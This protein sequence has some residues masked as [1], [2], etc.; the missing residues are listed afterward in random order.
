MDLRLEGKRSL[1]TGATAG[2]GEATARMLAAEGALVIANG[3]DS[4]KLDR[5]IREIEA[6]GGKAIPAL[7]DVE[8]D[9][10][11]A[12][13]EAVVRSAC[14]SIDV[15][16][17][18]VGGL[19]YQQHKAWHDVTLDDWMAGYRRN[20]GAA[21]GLINAFVPDMRK[22][23]WG[24]IIN[25]S[26]IAALEPN[27]VPPEYQAAKAALNNLTKSLSKELSASGVTANTITSGVVLT[28]TLEA[29][30]AKIA[31]DRGW[32]GSPDEHKQRYAREVRPIASDGLG[33]ADEIAYAITM[34]ASPRSRYING[35]NIRVDGGSLASV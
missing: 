5:V 22:A 17:N 20:V 23:G 6:N 16:I 8:T 28:P 30:I 21:V 35:A 12:S 13:V 10:G 4:R 34:V 33:V 15:L 2:I 31:Q 9:E 32:E 1:V 14:G 24:R 18:N 19:V 11:L 3:R 25:V 7:G 26:T 27:T 29:W